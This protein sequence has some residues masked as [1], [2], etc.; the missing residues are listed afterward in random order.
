MDGCQPDGTQAE[1]EIWDGDI[2]GISVPQSCICLGPAIRQPERVQRRWTIFFFA[3][4]K[5]A[6]REA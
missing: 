4:W 1:V 5:F 3:A 2:D 6:A